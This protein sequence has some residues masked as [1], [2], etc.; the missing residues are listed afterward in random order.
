M[1]QLI[2]SRNKQL[3]AHLVSEANDCLPTEFIRLEEKEK[4][5]TTVSF[6]PYAWTDSLASFTH[7][8]AFIPQNTKAF[9][10]VQC[11]LYKV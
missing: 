8:P 6:L 7:W 2:I 1:F 3:R 10:I 4:P 11:M 5:M 9:G